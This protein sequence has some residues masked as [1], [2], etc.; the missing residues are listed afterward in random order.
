[1]V[2]GHEGGFPAPPPASG[3]PSLLSPRAVCTLFVI[4]LLWL[5]A[6][7]L[8]C[9]NLYRLA[10]KEREEFS[11]FLANNGVMSSLLWEQKLKCLRGAWYQRYITTWQ[12]L[13]GFLDRW[14]NISSLSRS[15]LPCAFGGPRAS[16]WSLSQFS[17]YGAFFSTG[18]RSNL[19]FPHP[20][21]L[22]LAFVLQQLLLSFFGQLWLLEAK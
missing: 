14:I 13:G 17:L 15:P 18:L 9:I 11:F 19:S 8:S 16:A 21:P 4:L 12:R 22:C 6:F 7:S 2:D 1:M 3:L 5:N 20:Q 10:M